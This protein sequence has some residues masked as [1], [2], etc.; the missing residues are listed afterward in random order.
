MIFTLANRQSYK[1]WFYQNLSQEKIFYQFSYPEVISALDQAGFD[2][3]TAQG[4]NWPP[5][6]RASQSN[7]I[8][9]SG[10]LETKLHFTKCPGFSPSVFYIMRKK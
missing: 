7:L 5:F 1:A 10:N 9:W 2:L 8:A 6:G 3:I 4:Y